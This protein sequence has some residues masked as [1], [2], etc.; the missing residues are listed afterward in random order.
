MNRSY[1]WVSGVAALGLAALGCTAAMAQNTPE[2]N[3]AGVPPGTAAGSPQVA[4]PSAATPGTIGNEEQGRVDR[5]ATQRFIDEAVHANLAE[6]AAGRY[7]AAHSQNPQVQQFA[8]K[9]IHDHAVANDRLTMIARA[10]GY[11]TPLAPSHPDAASLQRLKQSHGRRFNADYAR[12][13]ERD[14]TEVI[15][16]FRRAEQDARIAPAVRHFANQT[17][18]ILQDHLHMANQ[19][20]ASEAGANHAAG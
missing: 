4:Q 3:P 9:M 18:P 7:A 1:A 11:A 5:A 10:H 12:A 14:H 17:L 15:S 20:V 16:L 19:L 13:Q 2:A 6:I 8:Q